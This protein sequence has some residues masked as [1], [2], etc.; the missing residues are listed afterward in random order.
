MNH[1]KILLLLHFFALKGLQVYAQDK[2]PGIIVELTSG[3]T[4]EYRLSD[5]PKLTYDGKTIILKAKGMKV[6][7]VPSEIAKVKTGIVSVSSGIDVLKAT[8]GTIK[9]DAGLIRLTGFA[10]GEKVRIYSSD[11]VL[12]TS[13]HISEVGSLVIPISSLPSGISIIKVNQQNIKITK[14]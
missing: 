2:V 12:A 10:K 11:G 6:E 8:Q 1:V 9:L 4:V 14:Q 7:Y 5:S 3:K 13:Y